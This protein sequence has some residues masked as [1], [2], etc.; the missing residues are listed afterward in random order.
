MNRD[1]ITLY[2]MPLFIAAVASVG[3]AAVP[4]PVDHDRQAIWDR[5]TPGPD[6]TWPVSTTTTG[7]SSP[8]STAPPTTTTSYEAG[9]D[10]NGGTEGGATDFVPPAP[11]SS[12]GEVWETPSTMY[13]LRGGMRNGQPVHEGAVAVNSGRYTALVGTS[14][15]VLDGPMAGRTFTVED[16]GPAAHFDMWTPSCEEA[17]N[18]GG[19]TIRVQRV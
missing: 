9:A 18:Y 3:I 2:V 12:T 19:R 4:A 6:T 14:W 8:A 10:V 11:G 17:T 16:M 1:K 7:T 13:C 5:P 15:Q